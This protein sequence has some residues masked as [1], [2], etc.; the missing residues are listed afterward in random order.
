MF[1]MLT[2]I[3]F[4]GLACSFF[5]VLFIFRQILTNQGTD[6]DAL[7]GYGK[8]FDQDKFIFL[9]LCCYSMSYA[10]IYC[11]CTDAIFSFLHES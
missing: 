5:G 8:E 9:Y 10:C 2:I 1:P 7:I 11:H 6:V 3:H 4:P